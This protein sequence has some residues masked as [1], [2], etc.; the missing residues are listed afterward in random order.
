MKENKNRNLSIVG[1]Y[2]LNPLGETPGTTKAEW[3]QA[4]KQ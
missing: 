4:N 2:Y 1:K 3:Q